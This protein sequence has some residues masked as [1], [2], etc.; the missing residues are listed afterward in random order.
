ME[1]ISK[2]DTSDLDNITKRWERW[3]LN[4]N[5]YFIIKGIKD[6]SIK[7]AHLFLYGG[8][9]LEDTYETVFSDK[10]TFTDI[11]RKLT[12]LFTPTITVGLHIHEFREIVQY[13]DELFDTFV[14]RLKD[15]AK[16]CNFEDST[17]KEIQYQIIKGCRSK[18]V[19]EKALSDSKLDL[20]KLLVIGKTDES[21]RKQMAAYETIQP[22]ASNVSSD[23][24]EEES[25]K[26]KMLKR[27][28]DDTRSK[29]PS[30]AYAEFDK[31][32]Q[33]KMKEDGKCFRCGGKYPHPN[34]QCPARNA[35]CYRCDNVGHFRQFCLTQRINGQSAKTSS[36]KMPKQS[37]KEDKKLDQILRAIN[38][39][40]KKEPRESSSDSDN[41]IFAIRPRTKPSDQMRARPEKD[42]RAT[43]HSTTGEAPNDLLFRSKPSTT[44]LPN[45]LG[46]D[47]IAKRAR[48]KDEIAKA[49]QAQRTD[50]K[51]KAKPHQMKIGDS[52]LLL[53]TVKGK[54]TTVYETS[55]YII[56]DVKGSMVTIKRGSR[57]LARNS[58]LLKKVSAPAIKPL[59]IE[60]EFIEDDAEEEVDE[61]EER[62]QNDNNNGEQDGQ[63][64]LQDLQ[65]NQSNVAH[66]SARNSPQA[67]QRVVRNTPLAR[68]AARDEIQRRSTRERRAPNRFD[69]NRINLVSESAS[70]EME[71]SNYESADD[72]SGSEL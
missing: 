22:K 6:E 58:S 44:G 23:E 65:L 25:N 26:I 59:I 13:D 21:V 36:S 55:H 14:G 66:S 31:A 47:E 68:S 19:K 33:D 41:D 46:D 32:A 38:Q 54:A 64:A 7:R 11:I 16:Q 52:V 20:K 9:E 35:T 53:Q 48:S 39:M 51:L 69:S 24:S 18:R 37:T 4:L 61:N 10:D 62:D 2:F 72:I 34:N 56:T 30:K 60:S 43:P 1:V 42:Y 50:I 63:E 67:Q 49:K 71:M 29:P 3:V 27:H 57:V 70:V 5:R 15:K 45:S 40:N 12:E 8:N 17:D 28:Y